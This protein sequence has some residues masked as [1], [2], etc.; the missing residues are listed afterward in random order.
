VTKQQG[1]GV[2]E[3]LGDL[4]AVLL[5]NHGATIVGVSVPV[6]VYLA[7]SLDRSVRMQQAAAM[8]GEVR[9][10]PPD[11]VAGMNRY[12]ANLYGDGISN[13]WNYLLR[14]SGFRPGS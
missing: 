10:I 1:E 4:R 7:V 12:F 13:T 11:Q 9:P 3:A 14:Q 6:A 5:R 2:A 8:L